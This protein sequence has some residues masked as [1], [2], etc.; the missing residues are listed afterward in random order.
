MKTAEEW[1]AEYA[2]THKNHINERIHMFCVPAIYWSLSALVWPPLFAL[3]LIFYLLLGRRE[4]MI[5]ATFTFLCLV[6]V[7]LISAT[8]LPLMWIAI[9]VFVVAWIGQFYG[10]KLEGRKPAFLNDI[11]FLLIGPLWVTRRMLRW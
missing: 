1:L 8:G 7:H 11:L 10:H 4:F 5:M 6:V 3:V 9:G 2:V